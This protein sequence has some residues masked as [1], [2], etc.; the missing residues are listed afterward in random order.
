MQEYGDF[1]YSDDANAARYLFLRAT[2]DINFFVEDKDKEYE[3]E[4]IFDRM[5]KGRYRINSIFGVG[6]KQQLKD[7][8]REFGVCDPESNAINIYLADGDFDIILT[9]SAMIHN[10]NFIYLKAYNIETY[11]IDENAI[12][13]YLR[14]VLKLRKKEV[15]TLLN[16]KSWYDKIV[17]QLSLIFLTHCF[18]QKHC[19]GIVNVQKGP[20]FFIDEKSRF[21]REGSHDKYINEIIEK[22]GNTLEQ[23][24]LLTD[25]IKNMYIE[26]YGN[27]FL[28]LLCGKYL[29]F[30]LYHYILGILDKK[31]LD[32]RLLKWDLIRHFDINKLNYLK[33]SVQELISV[34]N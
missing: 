28:Y 26:I 14:G 10:Q 4:E 24:T 23:I 8:F 20:G 33:E 31:N 34:S 16:F 22:S 7:R 13:E 3:Y 5:F 29:L 25:E 32:S 11:Y 30:S 17:E 27:D 15:K 6:G 2:N 18:V 12:I 1:I 21:E 19:Q 9:P